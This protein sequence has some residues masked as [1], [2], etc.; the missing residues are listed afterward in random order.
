MWKCFE[1]KSTFPDTRRRFH[2]A[3]WDTISR[4]LRGSRAQHGQ[5]NKYKCLDVQ[6]TI[7]YTYIKHVFCFIHISLS[8]YYIM[9]P[10]WGSQR[11]E[12]PKNFFKNVKKINWLPNKSFSYGFAPYIACAKLYIFPMISACAP[13]P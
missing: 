12:P 3:S 13:A 9:V 6:P 11:R 8:I 4:R 10:P 1:H 5:L 2:P 7:F